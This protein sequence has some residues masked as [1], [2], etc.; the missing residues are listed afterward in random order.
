MNFEDIKTNVQDEIKIKKEQEQKQENRIGVTVKATFG[1]G[2]K[3]QTKFDVEIKYK[4]MD[5]KLSSAENIA[6]KFME[7]K[8]TLTLVNSSYE[9]NN[10][11]DLKDLVEKGKI[12]SNNFDPPQNQR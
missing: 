10:K 9:N 3:P 8:K 2:K 5:A 7:P 1:N 6:K 11:T 4:M 12:N